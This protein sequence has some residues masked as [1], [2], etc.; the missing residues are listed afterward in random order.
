MSSV[1]VTGIA[2]VP[3]DDRGFV[4]GDGLFETMRVANRRIPLLDRHLERLGAGCLRLGIPAP[5]TASLA[6]RARTAAA[7]IDD[8]VVKLL[9]T[10]G[11]GGRGY[12]PPEAPCARI[13]V[14]QHT[15]PI[16]PRTWYR[17]GVRV[18]ICETRI[19]RSPATAGLKHL[20][21][22]EQVLASA[23]LTEDETEGLMLDEHHHVIEGTR[24]NV[25]LYLS[26]VLVTPRLD[27]SGVAGVMRALV[28]EYAQRIDVVC[29]ERTVELDDLR[30]ASEI[31]LTNA[32]LGVLPVTRIPSLG[33][34][35][36]RGPITV[37]LMEAAAVQGVTAWS[38]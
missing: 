24:C 18:R 14:S 4:Y 30:Q 22:I 19:G 37:R 6:H 7:T 36:E 21:R 13:V 1:D 23:E 8:G 29:Q 16:L 10:R 35:R 3:A 15:A 11:S 31:L 28:Q 17:E 5:S 27:M 33:W 25:F 26:G 2:S 9:L 32:V 20:G 12:R 34:Q 38:P